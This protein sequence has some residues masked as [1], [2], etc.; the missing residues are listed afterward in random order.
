MKLSQVLEIR[1]MGFKILHEPYGLYF[2]RALNTGRIY[3]ESDPLPRGNPFGLKAGEKIRM[4][5]NEFK[6]SPSDPDW[7]LYRIKPQGKE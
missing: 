5:R 2:T 7:I 6:R 4:F 3:W 1:K